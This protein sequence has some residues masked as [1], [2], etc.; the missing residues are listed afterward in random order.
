MSVRGGFVP[1]VPSWI[2]MI[3]VAISEAFFC[4][5]LFLEVV[6]FIPKSQQEWGNRKVK[7]L[8]GV[9]LCIWLAGLVL[10]WL[11]TVRSEEELEL[12]FLVAA[13]AWPS[14]VTFY[15]LSKMATRR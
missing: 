10:P 8:L 1:V 14:L 11:L 12:P 6:E 3:F 13:F 7:R 9:F 5:Y 15:L 4:G 2:L